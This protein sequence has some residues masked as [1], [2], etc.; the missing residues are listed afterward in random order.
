MEFCRYGGVYQ[1]IC[2]NSAICLLAKEYFNGDLTVTSE[3]MSR[4]NCPSEDIGRVVEDELKRKQAFESR[5]EEARKLDEIDPLNS[6]NDGS[7]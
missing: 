3:A 2:Q 7:A 1:D 4:S 6:P 5:L